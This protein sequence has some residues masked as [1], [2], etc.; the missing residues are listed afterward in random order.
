MLLLPLFEDVIFFSMMENI[1]TKT[2]WKIQSNVCPV[3]LPF[4]GICV[5]FIVAEFGHSVQGHGIA[6]YLASAPSSAYCP[7]FMSTELAEEP[8]VWRSPE[9][10]K[11]RNLTSQH[12][13]CALRFIFLPFISTACCWGLGG[14][15]NSILCVKN[16]IW[17]L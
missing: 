4:M 3:F 2:F 6:P 1:A 14:R 15:L 10:L 5:R 8:T 12:F 11:E 9:P 13:G 17:V 7:V 16:Y